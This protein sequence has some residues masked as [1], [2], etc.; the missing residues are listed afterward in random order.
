MY[1]TLFHLYD[2]LCFKDGSFFLIPEYTSVFIHVV[3][4]ILTIILCHF[5]PVANYAQ[6]DASSRAPLLRAGATGLYDESILESD[7][8]YSCKY[9]EVH[10]SSVTAATSC[11]PIGGGCTQ[12]VLVCPANNW[13]TFESE[14]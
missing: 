6:H 12:L 8:A 11:H 1:Q 2:F 7:S 5:P 13:F 9:R 10:M 4:V 14:L 3:L